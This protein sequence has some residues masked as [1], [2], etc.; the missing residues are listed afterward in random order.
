MS[1]DEDTI[2]LLKNV[3]C[4]TN[5]S[6]LKPP[7]KE[8]PYISL[9][10]LIKLSPINTKNLT[11]LTTENQNIIVPIVAVLAGISFGYDM[12]IGRQ[13][14][15]LVKG[16][17]VLDCKEESMIVNIWFIGCLLGALFGGILID[18]YGRRWT[19]ISTMVFLT[20]GSLL[21]ALS[22][23]Y[24]LFLIA[25]MICGY[26]GT[27]SA[28]AHCIYMSE[29]SIS[30]RRG[31][32]ITLHQ[33]GV[34]SGLLLSVIATEN[35]NLDYQ[36]RLTI[37]LTAVSSMITCIITII[38]LQRSPSF[39]LL[40]KV[41]NIKVSLNNSCCYVF[42]VLTIM[43]IMLSLSQGTGR[44]QVLYYAPRLFAL[45]GICTNIAKTTAMIALGIVRVFS[46]ILCLIVIERCG[47]RTALIT[48][49]TICM[50]SA[51]LL[52]LLATLDRGDE[53]LNFSNESCNIIINNNLK[54][55]LTNKIKSISLT[56]SSP[57]PL[58]PTPLA[59]SVP[60][61]EI[62]TQVKMSCETHNVI[63]TDGLTTELKTLAVITLLVFESAYTLGLGPVPLLTLNE[64][65]PAVIRGKC[66]GFSIFILWLI[67]IL[68]FESIEKM[69]KMMTLAGTYLFYSFMC[70]IT[71]FY[72][73]L[74]YPETK[75]KSLNRIGQE[76]RKI[77]IITRICN[78]VK[79]LPAI[80]H[81]QSI[82]KFKEKTN[83]STPI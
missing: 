13:I 48:S 66:I 27:V 65:F 64:I 73:F 7:L 18:Q 57:F 70:L 62:W 37:G 81:I 6:I 29:I 22:N 5:S 26:S 76:L 78:N 16:E 39:L 61:T 24:I 36:W 21:S 47:R 59:I 9:K 32:N 63:T 69:T 2:V 12:G 79:S 8:Y 10:K 43:I 19:M 33:L 31:C 83:Q 46:T 30:N 54:N 67:H 38:F 75:G 40:K 1:E 60:N 77:S 58:L 45:L 71:I 11:P 25:R 50:I 23:H 56:D 41:G 51:S 49:A 82:I 14:A 17:F 44:Q 20:F 28:I 55:E 42:E 3:N 68:L 52:S 34:A 35:K 80:S 4:N 72:V 15:P 53:L 74:V